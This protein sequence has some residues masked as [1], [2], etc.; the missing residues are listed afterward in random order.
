MGKRRNHREI[1]KY[2]A[3]NEDET[4]SFLNL[5]DAVK[6]MLMEILIAVNAYVRQERP[7]IKNLALKLKALQK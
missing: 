6:A 3:T 4:T 7:Q 1:R 2:F 5:Q